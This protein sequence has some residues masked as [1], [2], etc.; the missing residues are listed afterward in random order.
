E[1]NQLTLQAPR[2]GA[3][4]INSLYRRRVG[5][6]AKSTHFTGAALGR[7]KNQ[8]TLQAPRWGATKIDPPFRRRV[9]ARA[10]STHFPDA[11]LPRDQ[12]RPT[13]QTPR[14]GATERALRQRIEASFLEAGIRQDCES[15][16]CVAKQIST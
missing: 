7:E 6:R 15:K 16:K 5:A 3:S 13:F 10:K 1:K 9:G 12:N 2:W 14:W 11:P 4:K 8:L